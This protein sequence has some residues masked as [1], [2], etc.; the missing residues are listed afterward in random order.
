[1]NKLRHILLVC[2]MMSPVTSVSAHDTLTK[3]KWT[4]HMLWAM[5]FAYEQGSRYGLAQTT[6]A[7]VYAES[8]ACTNKVGTDK[9]SYGCGQLKYYT[10]NVIYRMY[11]FA[12]KPVSIANL[13]SND[14]LNI[15]LTAQYLDYCYQQM[16]H[17]LT[18]AVICYNRGE[19]YASTA[20][21]TLTA[22][23][24][25]LSSYLWIVNDYMRQIKALRISH[26]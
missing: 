5:N 11:D 6:E 18:K 24:V 8:T 15:I 25:K 7:I 14:R 16:H 17:N 19:Q 10:A 1:M 2:L 20:T 12:V 21:D 4:P 9:H 23:H 13:K 22:G 3:V 26:D